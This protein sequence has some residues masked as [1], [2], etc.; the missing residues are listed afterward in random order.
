MI[1]QP[2]LSGHHEEA[3]PKPSDSPS[4]LASI[5]IPSWNPLNWDTQCVAALMRYTRRPWELIVV[6]DGSCDETSAY[7]A[8]MRDDAAVP[9]T[10]IG[11]ITNRGVPAAINHGLRAARGQYL[12]VLDNDVVVTDSWLDQL[13]ALANMNRGNLENGS[14]EDI[15]AED[16]EIAA[17]KTEEST[18]EPERC[19][20]RREPRR[21]CAEGE[22]P[23]EPA[24]AL[25]SHGRHLFRCSRHQPHTVREFCRKFRRD[26]PTTVR[27]PCSKFRRDHR[28]AVREPCNRF[29]SS[30]S[31]SLNCDS[32]YRARLL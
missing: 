32:P 16:A 6:N 25:G 28:H 2:T 12:V 13:I 23:C 7:L 11:D 18:K 14:G 4:G 29:R 27:E 20:E 1:L 19:S 10:V 21:R 9:V 22:A 5:I 17:S 24:S 31:R 30:N 26:H 8:T 15:T 3:L